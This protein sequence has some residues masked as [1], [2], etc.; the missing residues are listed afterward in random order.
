MNE[1][2]R[3]ICLRHQALY[4]TNNATELT[5]ATKIKN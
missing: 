4:E 5:S 2:L 1:T 3:K